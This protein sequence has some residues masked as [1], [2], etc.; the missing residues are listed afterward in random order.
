MADLVCA[1]PRQAGQNFASLSSTVLCEHVFMMSCFS[2]TCF[3]MTSQDFMLCFHVGHMG[4]DSLSARYTH[5]GH[6]SGR[7]VFESGQ[8]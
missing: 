7:G 1:G 4:V 6:D 2:S 3:I 5:I 8:R